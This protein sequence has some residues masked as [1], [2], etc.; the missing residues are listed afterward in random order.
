MQSLEDKNLD[1]QERLGALHLGGG[2]ASLQKQHDG[3]K[4]TARE[5]ID[6]LLDAGSFQ[7]LGLFV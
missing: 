5:R 3:G 2:E 4:M 7:E 6:A 1:L